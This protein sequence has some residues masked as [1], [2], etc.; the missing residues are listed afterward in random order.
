MNG[1]RGEIR[2]TR[3]MSDRVAADNAYIEEWSPAL[4][5]AILIKTVPLVFHDP[6]AY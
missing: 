2:D 1:F 3:C 5:L 4:D 6:R